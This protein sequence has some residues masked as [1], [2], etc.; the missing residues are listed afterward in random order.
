MNST[1]ILQTEEQLVAKMTEPSPAVKEAI[2][3]I[4]GDIMLLGVAGKM[5]PSLAELLLRAGAKQVIGVARFSDPRQ[6]QYLDSVGVKTIQ[7]DLIDDQA[8]QHL[9]EVGHILFLAGHKL[10]STGKEPL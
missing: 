6:R 4:K 5:G 1:T 8:L 7:C 10:V 9:T 2:A 3:R